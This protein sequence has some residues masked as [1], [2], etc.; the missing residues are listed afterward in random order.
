MGLE[1]E[2][3]HDT[4]SEAVLEIMSEITLEITLEIIL[5]IKSEIK[6]ETRLKQRVRCYCCIDGGLRWEGG[7]ARHGAVAAS[8][9]RP[10]AH[11][12][13]PRP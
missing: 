12:E 2:Q 13:K 5:E 9:A 10:P 11:K 8:A 7:A 4:K 1:G 3:T 6:S